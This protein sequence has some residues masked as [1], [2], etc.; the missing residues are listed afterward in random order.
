MIG[1][2][3]AAQSRSGTLYSSGAVVLAGEA[4]VPRVL[5]ADWAQTQCLLSTAGVLSAKAEVPR[6]LGKARL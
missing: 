6:T 5:V 4:S 2:V 1:L 3:G